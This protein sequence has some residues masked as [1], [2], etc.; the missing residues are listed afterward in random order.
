MTDWIAP[1]VM[2]PFMFLEQDVAYV[3]QGTD[4]EIQQAVFTVLAYTID[5]FFPHP[6]FGV[7]DQL[8]RKGGVDL[9]Q[10]EAAVLEWEP[11]AAELFS[12]DS[13]W[14][15]TAVQTIAA[16]RQNDA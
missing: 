12:S 7:P 4:T 6:E 15:V 10:L 5:Q 3:E 13:A 11:R 14:L 1:H 2:Y 8:F 9:D 16:R